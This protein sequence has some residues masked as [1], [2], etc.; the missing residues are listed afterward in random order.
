V[1]G[2]GLVGPPAAGG[3]AAGGLE[4]VRP[5]GLAVRAF[6]QVQG[7]VAPA[8]ARDA[9]PCTPS[10][11]QPSDQTS[12]KMLLSAIEATWKLGVTIET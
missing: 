12:M 5:F 2:S 10:I 6:G 11:A 1:T 4:Q 3:R 8:V 7:D 9:P